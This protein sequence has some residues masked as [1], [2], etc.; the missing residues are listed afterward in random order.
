MGEREA[1][2]RHGGTHMSGAVGVAQALAQQHAVARVG[3]HRE[4]EQ[5]SAR[6]NGAHRRRYRVQVRHI[7]QDIGRQHEIV[8]RAYRRLAGEEFHQLA[9]LQPVVERLVARLRDHGSGEIDAGEA[10][11]HGPEGRAGEPG[12]AAEIEHGREPRQVGGACRRVDCRQQ[13]LRGAVIEALQQAFIET[14]GVL[15]EQAPHMGLHQ[16][17][18]GLA[19]AEAG[20]AQA[21]AVIVR[22][23][24]IAGGGKSRDRTLPVTGGLADGAEPEPGARKCRRALQH[25]LAE[26]PPPR[27]GRRGQGNPAP[28]G[29]AGRR[30]IA[31]G[32]EEGTVLH[33]RRSSKLAVAQL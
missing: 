24:G 10:V 29:S 22:R 17:G 5:T 9:G 4:A 1:R 14:R 8:L 26:S 7:D 32:D 28:I 12:A 11:D 25:L 18:R 27:L 30:Q 19:H 15:V 16:G 13:Q 23:I 20:E 31:G 2:P 6:Q 3:L 21:G 33:G